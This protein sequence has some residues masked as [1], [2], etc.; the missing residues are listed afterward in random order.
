MR[1]RSLD[2]EKKYLFCV[3]SFLL[4]VT[5][6]FNMLVIS[7]EELNDVEVWVGFELGLGLRNVFRWR[8]LKE[9]LKDYSDNSRSIG[10]QFNKLKVY[11]RSHFTCFKNENNVTWFMFQFLFLLFSLQ[12]SK[13]GFEV[14]SGFMGIW[15]TIHENIRYQKCKYL[16][17]P[18]LLS[19]FHFPGVSP[20]SICLDKLLIFKRNRQR[21]T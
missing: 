1:R 19:I 17:V 2:D 7:L 12:S 16:L 15:K 11:P 8:R 20:L 3:M 4:S 6:I 9:M 21:D 5:R 10:L 14:R 13:L 18:S